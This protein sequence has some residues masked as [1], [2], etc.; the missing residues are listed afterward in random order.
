MDDA[1]HVPAAN[2]AAVA[3][4]VTVLPQSVTRIE[5]AKGHPSRRRG[6]QECLRGGR[7]DVRIVVL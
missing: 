7:E 3:T 4:Q 6:G 2:V 5:E 1:A